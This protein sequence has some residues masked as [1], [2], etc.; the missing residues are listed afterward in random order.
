LC[1]TIDV[2][3][4]LAKLTGGEPPQ[5]RLIDGRDIWPLLL[6]DKNAKSPHEAFY[7]YWDDGLEAIRSGRWKLHFPHEYR[8]LAGEPG[9]D[10]QPGPYKAVKTEL[11]LFD[12]DADIGETTNVAAG[13]PEVVARL[14]ALGAQAR[15]DLGD[16]LTKHVG[17]NRRPA[18]K[19]RE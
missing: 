16:S 6:G 11:A 14:E 2:L 12:L 5:D 1:G 8:S 4:T 7:Y 19:L 15:E 13:H 10:G 17:K 18:G 9:K 3:P